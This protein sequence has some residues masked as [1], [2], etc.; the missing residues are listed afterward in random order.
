MGE[1]FSRRGRYYRAIKDGTKD[2]IAKVVVGLI[3]IGLIVI[4]L[5]FGTFFAMAVCSGEEVTTRLFGKSESLGENG[6]D[7]K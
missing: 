1:Y 5:A 6:K 3:V 7:A 2:G 4:V